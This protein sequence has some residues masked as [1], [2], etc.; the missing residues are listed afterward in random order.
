MK[1]YEIAAEVKPSARQL[2]WQKTEFYG[3][4]NFGL[5]TVVNR[6]WTDG[7]V[8]PT[9]FCPEEFNAQEWV[10]FFKEAGFKGM[11]LN[12][13]HHDGFCLWYSDYTDYSV[14]SSVNWDVETR[15]IVA[16]LSEECKNQGIKFGIAIS[17]LDRHEKS[18]G[19]G[20]EYNNYFKA[21]LREV[22]TKYGDIFYV[23][24]DGAAEPDK[25]GNVQEYDW[26]GYYDVVRECQPDAVIAMVGPDIRWYGNEWGVIRE[27]EWSVV[28][29][30]HSIYHAFERSKEVKKKRFFRKEEKFER[31]LG[32]R[33]AIKKESKF[34]WYPCEVCISM[35]DRWYYHKDDEYT[36]KTK[37]KLQKIYL[38]S[39]GN[40]C[41]LMVG[42]PPM[43]NGKFAEMDYQIL[44][45]FGVDLRRAYT[46]KVSQIGEITA[47]STL[48]P[49]YAASNLF[50]EDETKIWRPAADDM[51][52]ELTITLSQKDMFDKV[53]MME[54]IING[55]HVE[56]YEV[57][58]DEGTG[59]FKKVG[60]GGVIGYKRIHKINPVEVI[61]VKI[62][63]T[64]YRGNL[65]L[66][67]VVMY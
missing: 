34:I 52:P 54:N 11:V 62:K 53:V 32:S 46:Y 42:V 12:V 55:Q 19:K 63:I 38:E 39:V 6:E 22:L 27:N 3:F 10:T 35:R 47:S 2:E 18:Y 26:Q 58:I 41:G 64:S 20:E 24:F 45:A 5:P 43:K 30:R 37:D 40:N 65:E 60:S 59:K 36:A 23:R 13:K 14:E 7:N 16:L 50:D 44:K 48:S 66:Q 49:E 28:S 4:I 57:Y 8:N 15:D 61:R 17:P 56:G 31:D 33:K 1:P 25:D 9:N 21:L 51:E 67:S 29:E